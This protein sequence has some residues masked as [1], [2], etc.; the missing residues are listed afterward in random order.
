MEPIIV[1]I[2]SQRCTGYSGNTSHILNI[3]LAEDGKRY[4]FMCDVRYS[5]DGIWHTGNGYAFIELG[6]KNKTE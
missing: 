3:G 4:Q 1:K 2:E 6:G 5:E